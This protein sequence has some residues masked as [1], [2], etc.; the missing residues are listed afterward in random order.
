MANKEPKHEEFDLS[1]ALGAFDK[2]GLGLLKGHTHILNG[3]IDSDNIEKA[4]RW[5]IYENIDD[6]QKILTL[7]INSIGGN[8]NDA[9]GLIDLMRNSKHRIRT[10]GIGS[11][12][13][14]AFLIFMAGTKG[15]RYISKNSSILSHQYSDSIDSTKHHDIKSLTKECENMND[16]M[17]ELIRECTDLNIRTIKTKLLAPSDVWLKAEDLVELG[18]ADHIL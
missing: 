5:I 4:I 12:M 14:S 11:V 7:Y 15:E 9:F 3:E 8:L 13:S 17:I 18:A 16:R 6:E 1:D 10:I 2:I